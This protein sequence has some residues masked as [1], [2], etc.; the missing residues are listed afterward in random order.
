[1]ATDELQQLLDEVAG[2]LGW[3]YHKWFNG[4]G[5]WTKSKTPPKRNEPYEVHHPIRTVDD[6]LRVW[7]GGELKGWRWN[8]V[9]H[10]R[11]PA[12]TLFATPPKGLMSVATVPNTNN[13]THDFGMLTAACLKAKGK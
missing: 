9:S 6:L 3:H 13:F 10:G 8:K 12:T 4:G 5:G 2:L 7:E 1:M 11:I